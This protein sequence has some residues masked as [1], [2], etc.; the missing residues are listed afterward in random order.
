MDNE[1]IHQKVIDPDTVPLPV[2]PAGRNERLWKAVA[3]IDAFIE[4]NDPSQG[5]KNNKRR[6]KPKKIRQQRKR[7][8]MIRERDQREHE[9]EIL[10]E[11]RIKE[12]VR[13][14][15][16]AFNEYYDIYKDCDYDPADELSDDELWGMEWDYFSKHAVCSDDE[17][18]ANTNE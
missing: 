3:I 14:S 11:K 13:A 6:R 10:K 1:L 8:R 16:A 18:N 17:D 9:Q 5:Q 2:V 15:Q 7:L 4:C 12:A